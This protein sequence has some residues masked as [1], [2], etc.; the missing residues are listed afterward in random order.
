[1]ITHVRVSLFAVRLYIIWPQEVVSGQGLTKQKSSKCLLTCKMEF[2]FMRKKN[3]VSKYTVKT[4]E[5]E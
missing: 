2:L 4:Y 5:I 3:Q 1:M